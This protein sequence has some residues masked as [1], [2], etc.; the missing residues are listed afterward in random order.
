M[1]LTREGTKNRPENS[2]KQESQA[3][4]V[5]DVFFEWQD[6]VLSENGPSRPMTRFVL[7]ALGSH[8]NKYGGSC[9]PSYELLVKETKLSLRSVKRHMNLANDEGWFKRTAKKG[10]AKGWRSYEYQ[11]TIP[12]GGVTSA[13]PNSE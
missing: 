11:A 3:R 9:F 4:E 7:M 13:P 1:A 6:A 10:Q 2:L 12:I 5:C 8:M